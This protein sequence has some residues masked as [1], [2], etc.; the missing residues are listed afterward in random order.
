[1]T[2]EPM[3]NEPI[4]TG[5]QSPTLLAYINQIIQ[6]ITDAATQRGM[7]ATGKTLASLQAL[8]TDTGFEL[9]ANSNI[10]F[11]EHGRG[12]TTPGATAGNPDL[13]EIIAQWLDAR[14][15]N[16]NPYAVANAIHKN[17]TRLYQAG[18]NS[19]ILSVPLNLAAWDQVSDAIAEEYLDYAVGEIKPLLNWQ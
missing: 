12:P 3:T 16:I 15:L 8:P 11:M 14:G 17:G 18:G 10:Y 1:M 2:N 4:P 5:A 13:V 9:Q 6:E 7:Q 19:G